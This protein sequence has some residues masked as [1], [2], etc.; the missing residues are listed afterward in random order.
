M[1]VDFNAEFENNRPDVAL[2][3]WPG[4]MEQLGPATEAVMA[5]WRQYWRPQ[6]WSTEPNRVVT[7]F[8]DVTGPGGFAFTLSPVTARLYHCSRFDLF[9]YDQVHQ[10]MLRKACFE[11]AS[12]LHSCRA[13]YYAELVHTAFFD[14]GSLD[15]SLAVLR[16][17]HGD[18][19]AAISKISDQNESGCYY[20]DTFED[21]AFDW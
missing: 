15:E 5:K 7:R 14:G 19:A 1:S 2:G 3:R 11:I 9:V 21:L 13:I 12:L 18:P 17:E 20:V 16:R 4:L 6:S 8:T 10:E